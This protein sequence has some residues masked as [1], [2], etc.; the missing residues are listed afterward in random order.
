MDDASSVAVML[1]MVR[2]LAHTVVPPNRAIIFRMSPDLSTHALRPTRTHYPQIDALTHARTQTDT[3]TLPTHSCTYAHAHT[4]THMHTHKYPP[5]RTR[6]RLYT[7]AHIATHTHTQ[8]QGTTL[9]PRTATVCLFVCADA[10]CAASLSV[11]LCL[12][13]HHACTC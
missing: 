8:S 13:L 5:K 7:H 4:C 6:T 11:S 10:G 9:G 2:A 12:F 1:E 3:H